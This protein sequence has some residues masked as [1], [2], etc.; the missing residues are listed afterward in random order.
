MPQTPKPNSYFS[1]P[2]LVAFLRAALAHLPLEASQSFVRTLYEIASKPPHIRKGVSRAALLLDESVPVSRPSLTT[3][4][5]ALRSRCDNEKA[6]R[7]HRQPNSPLAP[8]L[9]F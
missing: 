8:C 2:F 3:F 7:I 5:E 1:C 9:H 4:V 6:K